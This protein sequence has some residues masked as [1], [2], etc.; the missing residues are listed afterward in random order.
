M[1]KLSEMVSNT[2]EFQ[3]L[4]IVA[5]E[6]LTVSRATGGSSVSQNASRMTENIDCA[7]TISRGNEN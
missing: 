1:T 5:S 3:Y 2:L 4:E 6:T 7:K